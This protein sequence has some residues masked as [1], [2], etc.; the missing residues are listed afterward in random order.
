MPCK[1]TS[2]FFFCVRH[3]PPF[4]PSTY[5]AHSVIRFIIDLFLFPLF[6]IFHDSCLCSCYIFPLSSCFTARTTA[7]TETNGLVWVKIWQSMAFR[8]RFGFVVTRVLNSSYRTFACNI[9]QV[10]LSASMLLRTVELAK[11]QK[12]VTRC[13]F[14]CIIGANT[15]EHILYSHRFYSLRR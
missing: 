3:F 10:L 11:Y 5:S 14:G 13:R 7:C 2:C 4:S 12:R 9:H 15:I 6:P 8:F 1:N